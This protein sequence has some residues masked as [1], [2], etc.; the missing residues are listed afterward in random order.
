MSSHM[1]N[2]DASRYTYTNLIR[3]ALQNVP[4]DGC[5]DRR[6]ATARPIVA[7]K[8]VRWVGEGET[9]RPGGWCLETPGGL[10]ARED[11]DA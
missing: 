10:V 6:E 9:R 2:V 4:N 8:S 7:L 5:R 3:N 11:E 1:Y